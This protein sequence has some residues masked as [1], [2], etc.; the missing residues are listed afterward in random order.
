M[1]TGI[2]DNI[3][4]AANNWFFTKKDYF[5]V[6]SAADTRLEGWFKAELLLLFSQLKAKGEIQDYHR[7]VNFK[8]PGGRY[9]IDFGVEYKGVIHYCEIKALCISQAAGTPRNL[10]FYFRDDHVGLIKDFKKLQGLRLENK[11]VMAF[12][13]PNP[14]IK[15][16]KELVHSIEDRLI[17]WEQITSPDQYPSYLFISLW[18]SK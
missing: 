7:E 10:D 17:N 2:M 12:I 13:Y 9:Q 4:Q 3:I 16:W 8:I 15:K 18:K 11:W 5:E 1:L 6:F 14:G